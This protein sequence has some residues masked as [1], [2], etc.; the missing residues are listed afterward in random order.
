MNETTTTRPI[1]AILAEIESLKQI[2]LSL[3]Q[4]EDYLRLA[5]RLA[6]LRQELREQGVEP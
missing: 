3:P 2:F 6:M 5:D 1:S 4:G